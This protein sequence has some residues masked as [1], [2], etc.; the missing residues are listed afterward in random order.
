MSE[1]LEGI[2][3]VDLSSSIAG[4]TATMLLGDHGADVLKAE[5]PTGD[6][7]RHFPASV[8]WHRGKRSVV[9]DPDVEAD[10]QALA[11]LVATA[12]VVVDDGARS[13]ALAGSGGE[14]PGAHE[15][16]VHVRITG[17]G[18]A[19]PL[20]DCSPADGLVQ[21][22]SGMQ[23]EQPGHRPGPV[24]YNSPLPSYGAAILAVMGTSAALFE[25]ERSGLGQRV[26]TSLLQG[27]LGWTALPWSRVERPSLGYVM[28]PSECRDVSS[29]PSYASG[30]G[31]WLHPMP[32]V[33]GAV[34]EELGLPAGSLRQRGRGC[35]AMRTFQTELQNLL[36]RRTRQEWLD[37]FW[38]KGLRAQPVLSVAEAYEHPQLAANGVIAELD[39]PGIGPVRQFAHPYRVRGRENRLHGPAPDVGAHTAVWTSAPVSTSTRASGDRERRGPL[40]GVRVLDFGLALAGP[41]GPMMLADLGADVIRI[42]N[43]RGRRVA[44]VTDAEQARAADRPEPVTQVWVACQRGKRS[45]S[46]DLKSRAGSEIA[47]AL[48]ASADVIHHNMRPGVAERLGIGYEDAKAVNPRIVY[49][50]V[51]GFGLTGPLADAP[52]SDQMGQALSGLE[53]EQGAGPAG[54]EPTWHR[55]GLTDHATALMSVV[56]TVQG[57]YLRERTGEPQFVDT[58]I[59]SAATFL[60][61]H[62][63]LAPVGSPL[64]AWHLD[65]DQTGIGTFVRLYATADGWLCV[66]CVDAA[67]RRGLVTQLGLP[68]DLGADLPATQ[69]DDGIADS[70]AR[71]LRTNTSA[72]WVELLD[73]ARV[74]CEAISDE[75]ND[76]WYVDPHIVENGLV[77]DYVHPQVGRVEQFGRLVHFSATPM[78]IERPPVV[79]GQH[80]GEIL[81]ELGYPPEAIEQVEHDGAVRSWSPTRE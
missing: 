67:A 28:Y 76:N 47:S 27:V 50:H 36:R 62:E 81:A 29:T 10:R 18:A 51:T 8:V 48:I 32:E 80:T 38:R 25:R 45:I 16:L 41:F 65:R 42:E 39:V 4:A 53:H 71:V 54:G 66:S 19:G 12:D 33:V 77:T 9:H 23:M 2:R 52:G 61:S 78:V 55:L 15:R 72:A 58:D 73:A 60:Q 21:A 6:P 79:P 56:A 17:Y 3:V 64:Q 70:I 13:P 30:D 1:I 7:T 59:L 40:A 75:F 63:F 69:H 46:L 68:P 43:A 49:C 20:A 26:E 57:L 24:Y 14:L 22:R 5:P 34:L 11:R 37:I 74:P 44:G 31:S 35:T